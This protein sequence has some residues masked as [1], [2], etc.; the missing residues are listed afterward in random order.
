MTL[1]YPLILETQLKFFQ[2]QFNSLMKKV[3]L[4]YKKDKTLNKERERERGG[5][6]GGG[7]GG[8]LRAPNES[9]PYWY[10]IIESIFIS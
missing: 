3:Y 8:E 5:G 2:K 7:G 9:P 4:I 6:G 10:V 1:K